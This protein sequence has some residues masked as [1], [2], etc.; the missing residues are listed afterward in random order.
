MS[1]L[2]YLPTRE[3]T[4]LD[5]ASFARKQDETVGG[6]IHN[7][8]SAECCPG[9]SFF[10]SR[11]TSAFGARTCTHTN[12]L[13]YPSFWH[14]GILAEEELLHLLSQNLA[15]FGISHIQSIMI[16]DER[17]LCRPHIPGL[18]RNILIYALS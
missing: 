16:D 14:F 8:K 11:T 6:P 10:T 7:K 5:E 1:L 4:L 2:L 3:N 13:W 15:G 18:L 12:L 17:T 9:I